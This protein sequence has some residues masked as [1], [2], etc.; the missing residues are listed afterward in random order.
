MLG[1]CDEVDEIGQ[2]VFIRF[3]EALPEFRGDSS[4]KTYLTRIA[5]NLS[6]NELKRR[7]RRFALFRP[8]D[9]AEQLHSTNDEPSGDMA[10]IEQ[11]LSRLSPEARDV[12][13]L[14]LVNGYSTEETA[15]MLAIPIG[16]V[17][18]RLSIARKKLR[19]LLAPHFADGIAP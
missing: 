16:T 1:R 4:V 6:L 14:R 5:I 18:S 2:Q 12:V 3:Y 9:D 13:V 8:V 10:L 11:A 17:L 19:D 15:E 7:K